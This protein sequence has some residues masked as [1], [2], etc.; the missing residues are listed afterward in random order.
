VR[1]ETGFFCKSND[2][3]GN[4]RRRKIDICDGAID[5]RITD[6]ATN[7]ANFS[8]RGFERGKDFA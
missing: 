6:C 8:M 7:D 5:Q 2:S 4:S 1:A 3:F